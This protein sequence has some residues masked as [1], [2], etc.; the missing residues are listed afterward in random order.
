MKRV[1]VVLGLVFAATSFGAAQA[2][3]NFSGTWVQISPAEGAGEIIQVKH[4][5]A[6]LVEGHD[7]EGGGH[8]L[9]YVLDGA[10]HAS[11]PISTG[12]GQITGRHKTTWDGPKLVIEETNDYPGGGHR[13]ARIVW[14]LNDKGQLVI[15]G[16]ESANG[17]SSEFTSTYRKQPLQW[18][19][20]QLRNNQLSHHLDHQ[21]GG[22]GEV[23]PVD[24]REGVAGFV[25]ER[26]RVLVA[27]FLGDA[28]RLEAQFPE[29]RVI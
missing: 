24:R 18:P 8:A 16:K 6:T 22:S 3:P 26:R 17:R 14:W 4:D 15:E 2:K 9:K 19:G 23:R 25:N 7:S 1:L 10:E 5:A 12:G 28:D 20:D 13:T 11:A 21:S 27:V 29:R